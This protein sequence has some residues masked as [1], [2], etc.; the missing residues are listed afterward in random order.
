VALDFF[1]WERRAQDSIAQGALTNSKRPSAFVKGIYP[2]HLV[3]GSGAKVTDFRG[4]QYL[5]FICGLGTNILG[6]ANERVNGA[7]AQQMSRGASL[8]L[9][10]TLEVET[11]EK[12][13]E[14]FPFVQAVKFLKTGAEAC[15]AA[16]RIARAATGRE[17]IYSE[18]YHGWHDGFTS[19]MSDPV[20][21]PPHYTSANMDLHGSVAWQKLTDDRQYLG[22]AAAVIVEPIITDT[23]KARIDWLKNLRDRCTRDGTLLI[24]DEIVT[25]FRYKKYGVSNVY[26]IE[27]DLICLGKAIANGMPLAAVGGKYSV[28]NAADYFVSSTYA[29]ESLTLAAAK[30]TMTLLQTRYLVDE[31]WLRGQ[32]FT[33]SFNAIWPEGVRLEGYPSRG[34]VVG[35]DPLT[36]ALFF[37]ET[38]KAGLLFGPSYFF[39]FAHFDEYKSALGVLKDVL[40]KIKSGNAKLEGEMPQAAVAERVR[41][42]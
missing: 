38:C 1:H 28:M 37:Q 20:G 2:T 29:G 25:G 39:S 42:S 24:F 26:G 36:R 5:D 6:Y 13:K 32:D 10:N 18:G 31:L 9:S 19:L 22:E 40:V 7:I 30:E 14:L 12:L 8:S 11:A 16:V 21:V 4:R 15:S 34:T 3:S 35:K 27:P 33:E 41:Q 17:V 23:S